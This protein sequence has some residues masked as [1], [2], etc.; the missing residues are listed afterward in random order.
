MEIRR[1]VA[2]DA[3]A[4]WETR[5]RGLKEFPDAF[6]TSIEEGLAT[7]PATLAKRFGGGD[8]GDFF[9][10]VFATDGTLSGCAGF[11]R[12]SRQKSR[13]IGTLIGVYVAPEFRGTG[14]GKKLLL[15]LIDEVRQVRGVEQLNLSVTHSNASARQL[16]LHA[17]FVPFGIEKNAIKVDGVYYDKEYMVLVL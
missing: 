14:S 12:K 17:G 2:A 9:L 5:N 11:E 16:Y 3:D 1:L 15:A 8:S 4:Y 13:H 7:S 6:T 10:G